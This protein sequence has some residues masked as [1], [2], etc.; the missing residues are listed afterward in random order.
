MADIYT[1]ERRRA[2]DNGSG[3]L[4]AFLA[5]TAIGAGLALLLAPRPGS[6]TRKAL[7]QSMEGAEGIIKANLDRGLALFDEAKARISEAIEAGK[8]AARRESQRLSREWSASQAQASGE[9]AQ[10]AAQGAGEPAGQ[11]PRG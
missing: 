11:T 6:E 3:A 2:T 10:A 4:V 9:G 8:E 5:G 1:D 7:R